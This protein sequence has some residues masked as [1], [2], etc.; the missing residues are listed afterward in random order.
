MTPDKLGESLHR[1]LS[2]I[3][4]KVP[5]TVGDPALIHFVSLFS[6]RYTPRLSLPCLMSWSATRALW[7]RWMRFI[8]RKEPQRRRVIP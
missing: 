4:Q 7:P 1:L 8:R 5:Q 3:Q 2:A 6:S